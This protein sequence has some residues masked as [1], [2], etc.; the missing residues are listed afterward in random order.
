MKP[1]GKWIRVWDPI[2]R[3][4]HWIL[5]A[6]FFTAYLTE[7]FLVAHVWAG[8]AVA[9]VVAVRL[10]WGL[11]GTRHA[12]FSDFVRSPRAVF[13]YLGDMLRHRARRYLGHNPAGGVMILALLFSLA[14]TASSGLVLYAYEEGAGPLAPLLVEQTARDGRGA[15][16][17]G[18]GDDRD[19]HDSRREHEA[20][21]VW[22]ELHELFANLTL[23]LV[24]LHV[25]GVLLSSLAHRENLVRAMIT[26]RKP[27][28]PEA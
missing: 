17:P 26:G 13:R 28:E 23:L 7:D 21:E 8:Y 24:V 18:Y 3:F 6:A 22:E 11:A 9:G 27:A 15:D 1:S 25:A 16:R 20:E 19:D 14:V 10:L 4:G 12:R 2:V 5:A